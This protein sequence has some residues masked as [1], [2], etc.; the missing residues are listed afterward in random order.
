MPTAVDIFALCRRHV[1]MLTASPGAFKAKSR[2][3]QVGHATGRAN[4]SPLLDRYPLP[5]ARGAGHHESSAKKEKAMPDDA[6]VYVERVT[7]EAQFA[8]PCP[9][10]PCHPTATAYRD[11]PAYERHEPR[12]AEG[13]CCCGRFFV[14]GQ[15]AEQALDHARVVASER[16]QEGTAPGGFVFQQQEVP[17]PWGG[18][19]TA[20]VGDFQ[21]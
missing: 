15:T 11:D 1:A 8:F 12:L 20:V 13:P 7:E 14:L 10:G 17:L 3:R 6:K 5:S 4:P 18:S 2:R 16:E 9:C 19:V 21:A